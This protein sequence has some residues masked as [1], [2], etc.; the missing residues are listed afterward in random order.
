[1]ERYT[2]KVSSAGN[3]GQ[4]TSASYQAEAASM[5]S[6]ASRLASF[7]QQMA[8]L[9]GE[10]SKEEGAADAMRYFNQQRQ[11]VNKI[12]ADPNLSED[13]KTEKIKKIQADSFSKGYGIYSKAYNT[14][15]KQ[16]Y[17][18]QISTDASA[19]ANLAVV[20][21]G[22]DP[23]A[24]MKM[25]SSF[26]Q[27]TVQ[28]APDDATAIVAQQTFTKIGASTF[29]TLAMAKG[30]KSTAAQKKSFTDAMEATSKLHSD[31]YYINDMVSAGN[32]MAQMASNAQ[33]AVDAGFITEDQKNVMLMSY[34][35]RAE[36]DAVKRRFGEE[37]NVGRGINVYDEFRMLEREGHFETQDPDE[38]AKLK[39]SMLSQIK[40]FNDGELEARRYEKERYEAVSN[41]TL[42][43]GQVLAAKGELTEEQITEWERGGVLS[44]GDAS[45]LRERTA[46]G[47]TREV[48]DAKSL[49]RYAESAVLVDT[50]VEAIVND[51][52]LSEKDKTALIKRRED[53]LAN[54]YNWTRTNDGKEA[55]RI[56]KS[57]F[58]IWEGTLMAKIDLDNQIMRDFDSLYKDF[59]AK[60]SAS[61]DPAGE[62]LTIANS[63]LGE[64]EQRK[65]E[66]KAAEEAA[67]KARRIEEAKNAAAA[68][69]DSILVKIGWRDPI[70]WEEAML[71]D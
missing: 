5:N 42:R 40:E 17:N 45:K 4:V 11:D 55:I 59:Y 38:I 66:E 18:N 49:S 39:S 6:L 27:Q 28:A 48:S 25:Y 22:G 13:E 21:S 30:S 14:Q 56:I 67:N 31:A 10:I 34:Q 63:L 26:S 44:S 15:M 70:T 29:K 65:L 32:Y 57:N 3:I 52:T 64:Y 1:M 36:L 23:A 53:L 58:G 20:K 69:N 19:A 35:N 33:A 24:F 61:E 7:S 50:D 8:G 60:V 51:T 46:I 68:H 12:N 41:E 16:A 71:K 62:V 2:S 47:S 43:E 37:L 9:A 54:K